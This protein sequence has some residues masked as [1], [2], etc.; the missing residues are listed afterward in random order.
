MIKG[1]KERGGDSGQGG[2]VTPLARGCG[3]GK[4]MREG[5]IEEEGPECIQNTDLACFVSCRCDKV[6]GTE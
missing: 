6:L 4:G 1:H 2:G 3:K 5:Q